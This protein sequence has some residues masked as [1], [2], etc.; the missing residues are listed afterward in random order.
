MKR[1]IITKPIDFTTITSADISVGSY[2]FGFDVNNG[3][4]LSKMDHGLTL[5]VIEGSG[6]GGG[7]GTASSISFVPNGD[8]SSNNVQ[9]AIVE[10]RDD[11]DAK[12]NDFQPSVQ[13]NIAVSAID[14]NFSHLYKTLS[15]N[16]TF[17]FSNVADAKTIIV[18]LTN[19]ASNYTVTWPAGI[20]WP[21]GAAPVMTAGVKIDVYTFVQINGVI[22]ASYIQNLS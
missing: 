16:T 10:V 18:A 15:E 3:G 11:I 14:W 19:T 7:G 21:G 1:G 20:K 5:S 8:I 22:H 12:L 9:N 13:S 2:L 6:G 17:T 4:K